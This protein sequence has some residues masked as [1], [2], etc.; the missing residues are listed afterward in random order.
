[1]EEDSIQFHFFW[2]SASTFPSAYWLGHCFVAF[3]QL[4][5][6]FIRGYLYCS[7]YKFSYCITHC[8]AFPYLTVTPWVWR[9]EPVYNLKN[10]C[11]EGVIKFQ[12][13]SFEKV[14]GRCLPVS[15]IDGVLCM[16]GWHFDFGLE[17]PNPWQ[18]HSV[19]TGLVGFKCNYWNESAFH[20][21]HPS[22]RIGLTWHKLSFC[23]GSYRCDLI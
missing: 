8:I 13:L 19:H 3:V 23:L 11:R 4:S 7:S 9:T 18:S 22:P 14:R 16:D 1:M 17:Y 5:A 12:L 2:R 10:L 21:N 6:S 15:L 20:L